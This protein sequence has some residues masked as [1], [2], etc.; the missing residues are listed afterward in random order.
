VRLKIYKPTKHFLEANSHLFN[1]FKNIFRAFSVRIG[2][3]RGALPRD[4]FDVATRSCEKWGVTA[5]VCQL[6]QDEFDRYNIPLYFI[7]ISNVWQVQEKLFY[8]YVKLTGIPLDSVDLDQPNTIM[9]S[10]LNERG[11]SSLD[12]LPYMREKA[13][14]G[15]KLYGGIDRHLSAGGHYTI[16]KYIFPVVD[17]RLAPLIKEKLR[18][19]SYEK[20]SSTD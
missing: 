16:A 3:T 2:R 1:L 13:E 14:N 7:I 4:W 17:E 12:P 20:P 10:V 6:M 19:K 11:L 18:N 9:A 8:D 15:M 5:D